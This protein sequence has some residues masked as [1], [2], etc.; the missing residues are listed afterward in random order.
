MEGHGSRWP[1]IVD[2]EDRDGDDG[3]HGDIETETTLPLETETTLEDGDDIVSVG[4]AG[5]DTGGRRQPVRP[6]SVGAAGDDTGASRDSAGSSMVDEVDTESSHEVGDD[7]G[8]S[9]DSAGAA[10]STEPAPPYPPGVFFEEAAT[11]AWAEPAEPAANAE[12][13]AEWAAWTEWERARVD[14]QVREDLI[15]G[16][17][18]GRLMEHGTIWA[19]GIEHAEAWIDQAEAVAAAAVAEVQ[20]ARAAAVW[21]MV[22]AEARLGGGRA[23]RM[24]GRR[25]VEA[26][27]RV[28]EL[29]EEGRRA[30]EGAA[31]WMEVA[32]GGQGRVAVDVCLLAEGVRWVVEELREAEEVAERMRRRRRRRRRRREGR[33][34]ALR[35]LHPPALPPH[36]PGW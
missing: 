33:I 23:A 28:A 14:R 11:A 30:V 25:V 13:R 21:N 9:R 29:V 34:P 27:G 3:A 16:R 2:G 35:T 18:H 8:A 17:W 5:D 1:W 36:H 10:E 6:E 12:W 31:G 26:T 20:E 15:T 7:T 32:D 24:A 22:V 19:D 4:A